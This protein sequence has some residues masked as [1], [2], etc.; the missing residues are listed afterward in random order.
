MQAIHPCASTYSFINNYTH[1]WP[2]S[3]SLQSSN[4]Y[5]QT[6]IGIYGQQINFSGPSQLQVVDSSVNQQRRPRKARSTNE[7][8]AQSIDKNFRR[9]QC[10]L[11]TMPVEVKATKLNTLKMASEYIQYLMDLLSDDAHNMKTNDFQ[12][13][14]KPAKR[15]KIKTK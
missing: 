3:M 15:V 7:P 1:I 13:R 14:P 8:Y 6:Q 11:P 12:F 10:C 4:T 2:V 5:K 9:L